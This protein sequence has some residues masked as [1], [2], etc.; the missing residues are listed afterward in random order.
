MP[1][2]RK[3][4]RC[5]NSLRRITTRLRTGSMLPSKGCTDKIFSVCDTL[6][7]IPVLDTYVVCSE[8]YFLVFL[9]C[10]KFILSTFFF[11]STIYAINK[12]YVTKAI[13]YHS[14]PNKEE[15]FREEQISKDCRLVKV[16]NINQSINYLD[17]N[18]Y[19][20]RK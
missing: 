5:R 13:K 6:D 15:R 2:V 12:Y 3:V 8:N 11:I 16:W 20:S 18:N 14:F 9:Y 4:S 19:R 17:D 7:Q 1:C 10:D